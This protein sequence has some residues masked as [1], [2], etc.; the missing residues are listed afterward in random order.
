VRLFDFCHG[1]SGKILKAI[2]RTAFKNYL[3]QLPAIPGRQLWRSLL[4]VLRHAP[5]SGGTEAAPALAFSR[6]R[7]PGRTP[8]MLSELAKYRD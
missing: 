6:R 2:M 7:G 3:R 1:A 4:L 5:L 8:R